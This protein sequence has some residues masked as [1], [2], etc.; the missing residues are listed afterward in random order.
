MHKKAK[1]CIDDMIIKSKERNGHVLTL[2]NFF[3][4]L[5]KY[6]MRM[7]LQKYGFGVTSGKLL[8]HMISLRG[9]EVD[10]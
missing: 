7:N 3:A 1:V 9:I 2:Q 10:P 8:G 5:R 6:S 4:K